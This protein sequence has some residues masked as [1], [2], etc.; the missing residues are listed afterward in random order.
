[1]KKQLLI[2][3]VLVSFSSFAQEKGLY[4]D[5][6]LDF[7]Y[8]FNSKDKM[9]TLGMGDLI[10][11]Y[12]FSEKFRLGFSF[13][14]YYMRLKKDGK[15]NN[16]FTSGLGLNINTLL[17]KSENVSLRGE[18]GLTVDSFTKDASEWI[19]FRPS[20][21]IQF[22]PTKLGSE[23]IKPYATIGL[24]NYNLYYDE[25]E[26]EKSQKYFVPYIGIGFTYHQ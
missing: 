8:N 3:L 6:R 19:F 7:G 22:F 4:S 21:G 12:Q 26:V 11:G 5:A 23:K 17:Y 20:V 2:L 1:M 9:V 14:T 18:I 25:G 10:L 24:R 13:A 16:K 15:T